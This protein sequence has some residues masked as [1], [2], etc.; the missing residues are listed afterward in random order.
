MSDHAAGWRNAEVFRFLDAHYAPPS[1]KAELAYALGDG[2]RLVET[3]TFPYAPWPPEPSRQEAFGAALNILHLVAGVSYFKAV[4][5]PRI[6]IAS[7]PIGPVLAGFL[8]ELYVQGLAE[9]AFVN[10]LDLRSTISFGAIADRANGAGKAVDLVLPERALVAMG[11]GKDSLVALTMLQQQGV[12]VQ[13]VCVGSSTLIEDTV[14]AAG[15]PLLRIERELAPELTVMNREGALNGHVPVT[16]IN[17]AIL[18]CAAI[19]YG[20]RYVVFAN[21]RSADEATRNDS[22]HGAINH[23]YSKTSAFESGFRKVIA[24]QVSPDIEYFSIL[25]PF[26]ELEIARRFSR[27]PQFHGVFSS[28][29]RNFHLDGSRTAGRWCGDCP[30]C[31]FTALAL[32]VFMTPEEVAAILGRDLLDAPGQLE[33]FRALCGLGGDKPFECVGGIGE[34]RAALSQLVADP[35]WRDHAVVKTLAPALETVE[36]PDLDTILQPSTR[37]FVPRE[38]FHHDP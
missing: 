33:G 28:C 36:V 10:Q 16:A 6:A 21:E 30:K 26:A 38:I 12:E 8:D 35:K 19:L 29:N 24:H 25:R 17:S 4:A 37:H 7:D 11:G 9:F 32:G 13:P 31:R 27:L 2:P 15:L 3:I 34:C 23:Q 14:R 5:P 1:G 20:F 22:A 18:L